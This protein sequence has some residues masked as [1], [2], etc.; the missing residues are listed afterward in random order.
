MAALGP[1][2]IRRSG[3][4]KLVTTL[5]LVAVLAGGTLLAAN[6][7]GVSG[8]ATTPTLHLTST[9][10][11]VTCDNSNPSAPICSGLAA[12]DVVTISGGNFTAGS[13]ASIEQCS[14]D[15][16][17][18]QILFLGND[19]PVSCSPLALTSISSKGVLAG[20]KTMKTGTVGPPSA[21]TPTCTQTVPKTSVITGCSTSGNA[22]TD[23]ATFPCPPTTTQQAAGDTCVLAIGDQAGDRAI[24]IALFGTE[25]LPTTTTTTGGSTSTTG[26]TTSTT[27]T[28]TT[29]T[30]PTS[31]STATQVSASALTLGTSGS[32]SDTVTVRG[33][34]THGSPT[35]NVNF[36]V[37]QTGTSNTLI[38]G[39][40][41]ATT[42]A[43]LSTAHLT[44]GTGNTA[45]TS[46]G[47]FT[48]TSAG[49]WCFSAVYGGD[50]IYTGSSDNTT[51]ANLDANECVLV[52]PSPS[53]TSTFISSAKLTLGPLNSAADTVTVLGNV[54]GGAPTGG[55]TFYACHTS[56]TAT[57]TVGP[58][59]TTG[60]PQD[61]GVALLTGAGATSAATSSIFVPT[62][63]GTWCFSAVY[64]GSSTYSGSSDNTSSTNL[65]SNECLL[66][67]P[68]SADAI[69]SDPN[70][71]AR[72][73]FSSSFLITTSGSPTA[74]VK[75]KGQLPKGVHFKNNHNGTATIS[76]IPNLNKSIGVYHLTIL[77]TFGKG[78]TKHIVTQAFIYTVT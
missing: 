30:S 56:V 14:S 55:V 40:C 36:Y 45:S 58:C 9:A 38:R 62:S 1:W 16:T 8:A 49:T 72:A 64:G 51:S 10:A 34:P 53:T 4:I 70:A 37:C 32:V 7:V 76:G 57:F 17:Q 78:K 73:G 31:T 23:A 50:S 67:V 27:G 71:S 69:T 13:L 48:P 41:A 59:P 5:G 18:P 21:G 60:T 44:A 39:P 29:T 24:G 61:A 46:S 15:P 25:T 12:G 26:A 22:A 74:V 35:G 63:V 2:P 65:D 68:P 11:G 33:T 75:K 3:V 77:A 20:T 42:G 66:V 19:I 52:S 47:S 6:V 54:V 28:T 43:H